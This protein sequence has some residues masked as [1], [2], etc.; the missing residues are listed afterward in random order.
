MAKK[1]RCKQCY[2]LALNR[3]VGSKGFCSEDCH[4]LYRTT[5]KLRKRINHVTGVPL[6]K[7]QVVFYNYK[8][9]L[10]PIKNGYGYYGTV[11]YSKNKELVQ[12]HECGLGYRSLSSHIPAH[13]MT[14]TDYREKY[15]LAG[16]T[17]LIGEATRELLV[18]VYE[19]Q[20]HKFVANLKRVHTKAITGSIEHNKS[21]I[22]TVISLETRNKRGNCPDQLLD[23]IR[24]LKEEL[25]RMPSVKDFQ[26]KYDTKHTG[27]IYYTFG[28]WV[29][30][31]EMAGL[32]SYKQER[33]ERYND[34]KL[35][36]YLQLFYRQHGKT[37]RSSDM[38]RGI[39]PSPNVFIR[40]FG[41][42]NKARMF[43]GIPIIVPT[44]Y[45]AFIETMDYNKYLQLDIK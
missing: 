25:G 8:E 40:R 38:H 11:G 2:K 15:K 4:V 31:C 5:A 21:R 24:K 27:T 14:A 42:L 13:K 17:K 18:D 28:S 36:E 26:A 6:D 29:K 22:G 16:S 37:P 43:A 9:P 34:D 44:K 35:I 45:F 19:R 12:C 20:K 10:T 1:G 30:A 3:P 32:K 41:S 33:A 23:M 7:D 39:L